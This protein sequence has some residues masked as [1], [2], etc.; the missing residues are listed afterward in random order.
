MGLRCLCGVKEKVP[1]AAL[2]DPCQCPIAPSFEMEKGG[3]QIQR[4]I[5]NLQGLYRGFDIGFE[6]LEKLW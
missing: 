1:A 5:P 4:R 6:A 3:R 2:S